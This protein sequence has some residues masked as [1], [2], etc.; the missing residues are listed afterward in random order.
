MVHLVTASVNVPEKYAVAPG[1]RKGHS[2]GGDSMPTTFDA[3]AVPNV[4]V[5]PT[6]GG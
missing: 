5:L 3:P 4:V 6:I 1:I 2:L